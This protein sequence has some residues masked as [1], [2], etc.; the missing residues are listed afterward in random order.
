M[1]NHELFYAESERGLDIS[2]SGFT[3]VKVTV[4]IPRRLKV[5]IEGLSCY[6][7]YSEFKKHQ[8]LCFTRFLDANDC[9]LVLTKASPAVGYSKRAGFFCHHIAIHESNRPLQN[10]ASLLYSDLLETRWD[11]RVEEIRA[12]RPIPNIVNRAIESDTW[13]S[14]FGNRAAAGKFLIK[15][16][17]ACSVYLPVSSS[18]RGIALIEQVLS[19]TPE[20]DHWKHTFTSSLSSDIERDLCAIKCF[21]KAASSRLTINQAQVFR[22]SDAQ[23]KG[24]AEVN[25]VENVA[26]TGGRIEESSSHELGLL[27]S[28][29][30]TSHASKQLV[31]HSESPIPHV[32]NNPENPSRRDSKPAFKEAY[33]QAEPPP[34][35]SAASVL[36]GFLIGLFVVLAV[37]VPLAI[38][39]WNQIDRTEKQ[40][41]ALAAEN[42]D[43]GRANSQMIDGIK[44]D[45]LKQDAL[46]QQFERFKRGIS[47]SIS[48]KLRRHD[49]R[50]FEDIGPYQ[51]AISSLKPRKDFEDLKD[52][53][54]LARNGLHEEFRISKADFEWKIFALTYE[55]LDLNSK[56][57]TRGALQRVPDEP[58]RPIFV[59]NKKGVVHL[60]FP[61]AALDNVAVQ[62]VITCEDRP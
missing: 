20:Q 57:A 16:R 49:L 18:A 51:E 22:F 55:N 61:N 7:N 53:E 21:P 17:D 11:G 50:L 25:A 15:L 19:L 28:A 37:G 45:K 40:A 26:I 12:C 54:R 23:Y 29:K 44:K 42:K 43:M 2:S 38:S 14:E 31:L 8:K 39:F 24:V 35:I 13:E 3:T 47:D 60:R 34:K 6:D 59:A 58:E 62:V 9:W 56:L 41:L 5:F 27:P 46:E 30:G 10:P 48:E 1:Q 52:A 4:G 36:L 33:G 32:L